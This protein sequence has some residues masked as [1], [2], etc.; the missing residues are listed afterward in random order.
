MKAEGFRR[1]GPHQHTLLWRAL[2]A[3]DPAKGFGA[4]IAGKHWYWY[5]R[6]VKVV[7]EHCIEKRDL[8]T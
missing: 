2:G 4:L 8:Y 7:L 1:F 5:E 3:K 6:W